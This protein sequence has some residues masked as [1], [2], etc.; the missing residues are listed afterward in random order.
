[1]FILNTK[2]SGWVSS[3]KLGTTVTL[4]LHCISTL[5]HTNPNKYNFLLHFLMETCINR[6]FKTSEPRSV[7]G[8]FQFIKVLLGRHYYSRS[9]T[10]VSDTH[11]WRF[12]PISTTPHFNTL[13]IQRMLNK[14]R[15]EEGQKRTQKKGNFWHHSSPD[16][17]LPRHSSPLPPRNVRGQKGSVRKKDQWRTKK[18]KKKIEGRGWDEKRSEPYHRPQDYET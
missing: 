13:I 16:K 6:K 11:S 17:K 4:H 9:L 5:V 18:K 8:S 2:G 3:D 15:K 10:P 14:T 1:M 7:Y 12:W